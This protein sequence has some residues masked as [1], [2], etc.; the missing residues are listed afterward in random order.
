MIRPV[1]T[2]S[3]DLLAINN[4]IIAIFDG[5]GSKG[6][7]VRASIRLAPPLTPI[8]LCPGYARQ[9]LLLQFFTS[10]FQD[11]G[12]ND[13]RTPH[14]NTR[15]SVISP[16]FVKDKLFNIAMLL[17]TIFF[18]PGQTQPPL[19]SK[20]LGHRAMVSPILF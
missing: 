9:P 15:Y 16:H 19:L 12:S 14:I 20:F 1:R 17:P 2:R 13:L 6:S 11:T 18:W 4:K 3:P 8:Y 5:P 7:Q 10:T